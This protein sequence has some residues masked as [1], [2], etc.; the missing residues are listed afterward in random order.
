MKPH[1]N[2]FMQLNKI[3]KSFSHMELKEYIL[4]K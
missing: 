4:K 2:K 3:L 1:K